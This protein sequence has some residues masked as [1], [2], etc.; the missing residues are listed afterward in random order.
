M[1][2]VH[3]C[4]PRDLP[5]GRDRE[6]KIIVNT[7]SSA[8]DWGSGLSPF[9]VGPCRMYG[10]H[11]ATRMEN[12]WQFTKVYSHVHGTPM[13]DASGLPNENYWKWAEKGWSDHYAH[14]YPAGKGA[15]PLYS[16][17]DDRNL[18]YVEARKTIYIPLYSAAVADT[19]AFQRLM[20][21]YETAAEELWLWD[22]DGYDHRAL[23]MTW[24]QV[25][26][27]PARKMGHAF[28]LGMML[29]NALKECHQEDAPDRHLQRATTPAQQSLWEE[30]T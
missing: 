26:D 2:E 15:I 17:W 6:G 27:N 12:A 7:T 21:I 1:K 10:G 5:R 23:G 20:A 14:R 28:V 9:L 19:E 16:Y 29:E 3:I 30:I 11:N 25:L 18:G 24:R 8:G 13:V 4:G 22:F